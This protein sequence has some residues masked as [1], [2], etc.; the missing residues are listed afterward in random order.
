MIYRG[1]NQHSLGELLPQGCS[2]FKKTL[3]DAKGTANHWNDTARATEI[4]AQ[5]KAFSDVFTTAQVEQW[6]INPAVHYNAW[7][8]MQKADF[9]PV[10]AAFKDL[11]EFFSCP[12]CLSLL[13]L[14]KTGHK[15][16]ALKCAY[17]ENL[18]HLSQ[19][20]FGTCYKMM[21]HNPVAKAERAK[22]SDIAARFAFAVTFAEP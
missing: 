15:K 19:V 16:D 21:R 7:E 20:S 22:T 12:K 14:S 10:V 5:E 4:E 18:Q 17:S 13:M 9:E 2:R 6:A 3:R 11:C 1:D 8:N